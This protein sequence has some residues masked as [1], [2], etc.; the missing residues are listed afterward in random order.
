MIVFDAEPENTSGTGAPT[1]TS[2]TMPITGRYNPNDP[3]PQQFRNPVHCAELSHDNL[4]YVCDRVNDRIQVFKP[5]GTFIKEKFIK[6]QT[7]GSGSVWDIA[8]SKDPQQ[9]YIYLADGENDRVHISIADSLEVLTNFRRRRP[10][11]RRILRRAQH[12]DRFEG[13]HLHDRNLSRAARA[14]VRLQ[15][16]WAGDQSGSGRGVA[17]ETVNGYIRFGGGDA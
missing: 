6:K 14:E 4:L 17:E 11:A 1:G 2:R 16:T 3:P 10:S 13:Q 5:D 8:F 7:L 12:R 15:R 9:K